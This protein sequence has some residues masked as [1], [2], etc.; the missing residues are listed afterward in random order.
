[1][2]THGNEFDNR[3]GYMPAMTADF[4][5]DEEVAAIAQYVG[6]L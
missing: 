3:G 6:S 1:V 5:S 4:I 2:A